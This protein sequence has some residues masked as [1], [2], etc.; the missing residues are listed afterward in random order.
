MERRKDM[1]QKNQDILNSQMAAGAMIIAGESFGKNKTVELDQDLFA[2][3]AESIKKTDN[4]KTYSTEDISI[5]IKAYFKRFKVDF[6]MTSAAM[7]SLVTKT[8]KT[9]LA[10]KDL[11][12]HI[13]K[14]KTCETNSYGIQIICKEL[15]ISY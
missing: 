8:S 10:A 1:T 4:G 15:R 5:G 2:L 3:I 6:F 7:L 12:R 14:A 9:T 11:L 13:K